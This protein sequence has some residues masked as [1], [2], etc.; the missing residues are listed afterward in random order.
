V[1]DPERLDL[2]QP[3]ETGDLL[4]TAIAVY[5]RNF[6]TIFAIAAAIVVPVQLI[7]SGIGMEELA[8]PYERSTDTAEMLVTTAVSFLVVA[9]LIAAAT[10]HVLQE[11]SR[12]ERP[13]AGRA[14]QVGLDVFAPVFLAVLLAGLGIAIGLAALILPGIY[15]AVRWLFVP[16][17]VV[18]GQARGVDALR[19]SW[20]LTQGF[21]WRAFLVILL[22]NLIAFLPGILVVSPFDALAESA[23]RQWISLAGMTLAEVITAPFVALVST[24]LFFDLR[25]RRAATTT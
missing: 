11:L 12:G 20:A 7:V 22:A 16:Q 13:H 18:V 1:S 2:A 24:L 9:P 15:V 17:A 25:S 23:D 21:W 10:I 19:Q 5:R 4:G 6:P 8:A 3:R 14:I